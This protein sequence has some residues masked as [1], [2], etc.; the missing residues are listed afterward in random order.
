M[1][2]RLDE[3]ESAEENDEQLWVWWEKDWVGCRWVGGYD[4]FGGEKGGECLLDR[5]DVCGR[6]FRSVPFGVGLWRG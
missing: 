5:T 4:D 2:R 1:R 6:V 3:E